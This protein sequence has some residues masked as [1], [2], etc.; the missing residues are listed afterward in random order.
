MRRLALLIGA[1]I[2]LAAAHPAAAVERGIG[3][4]GKFFDPNRIVVLV[5]DT[6]TWRNSDS[7]THDVTADDHSF[8]SGRMPPGASFSQVFSEQGIHPYHCAI[9]KYMRAEVAVYAL[10]LSGPREPVS[11]GRKA[12]LTGLAPP[13]TARIV[14]R[15]RQ[16]NGALVDVATAPVGPDGGFRFVVI[17]D[18]PATYTATAR[19]LTSAP[20]RLRVAARVALAVRRRGGRVLVAVATDPAQPRAAVRLQVYSR[21]LFAWVGYARGRLDAKSSARFAVSPRRVLHL[22][23][24]LPHGV[25]G[26][27]RAVSRVVVVRPRSQPQRRRPATS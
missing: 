18:A 2:V 25:G 9:H 4:P 8:D 21:E 10:I 15:R 22:R 26:Y 6:V 17:A 24:V 3:I 5:G 27:G 7:S 1:M 20:L 19:D 12:V 11:R 23:A 14:L 16:A 13:E